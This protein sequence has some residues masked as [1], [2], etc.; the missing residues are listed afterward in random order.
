MKTI[1]EWLEEEAGLTLSI[2]SLTSYISRVRRRELRYSAAQPATAPQP[3]ADESTVTPSCMADS[4]NAA[5]H[6]PLA[7]AMAIL[8]QRRFD[9]REMHGDGDP[10]DK[11]LI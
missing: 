9:I 3:Q 4:C 8:R 10:T 11:N 5:P 7:S 1:R 6:N 2:T